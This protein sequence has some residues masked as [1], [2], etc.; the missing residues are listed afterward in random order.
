V[1][2]IATTDVMVNRMDSGYYGGLGGSDEEK[3][4]LFVLQ[5]AGQ[6]RRREENENREKERDCKN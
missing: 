4:C 3:I 5:I 2:V 6:N 1:W